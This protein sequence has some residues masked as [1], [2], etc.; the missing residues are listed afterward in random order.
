MSPR[1]PIFLYFHR[2]S[3][4]RRGEQG[5]LAGRAAEGRGGGGWSREGPR[6]REPNKRGREG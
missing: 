1:F 4:V 6:A 3:W 2:P 5:V